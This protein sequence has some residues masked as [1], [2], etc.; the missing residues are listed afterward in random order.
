M[1]R[2]IHKWYSPRLN[3]DMEIAMYGHF[4]F[5]LLIAVLVERVALVYLSICRS[6]HLEMLHT[7]QENDL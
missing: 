1:N 3:K 2:E 5:A 4:G 6:K 7:W